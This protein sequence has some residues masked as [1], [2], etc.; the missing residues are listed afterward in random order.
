MVALSPET[1]F[2]RCPNC[3]KV[4]ES[5]AILN[6]PSPCC[7]VPR[8][9]CLP[10]PKPE[11]FRMY[12]LLFEKN[13]AYANQAEIEQRQIIVFL[14]TMLEM[15][16]EDCLWELLEINNCPSHIAEILLD[17]NRNRDPRLG[18]YKKLSNQKLSK[19]LKSKDEYKDFFG[20]WASIVEARNNIIH[21]GNYSNA[22]EIFPTVKRVRDKS[23]GAFL[24]IN[25]EIY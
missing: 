21:Q 3:R 2:I 4:H 15:L 11:I 16:L 18:L 20:D 8:K 1:N 7:N 13:Q 17:S 25:N 9:D 22:Q 14:C 5:W 12:E 23:L 6:S 19:V 24:E 10:W